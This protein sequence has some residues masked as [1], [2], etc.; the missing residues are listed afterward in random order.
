MDANGAVEV[1]RID[2]DSLAAVS[3]MAANNETGVLNPWKEIA[4]A[5]HAA[6]IPFHC[7]ASQWIGK[8]SLEGLSVCDYV[9]GCAHKF[10]GPKGVGFFARSR[11]G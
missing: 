4:L 9:T 6:E 8:L 7:D 3:V 1:S 2:F 11:I 5:A 10:G